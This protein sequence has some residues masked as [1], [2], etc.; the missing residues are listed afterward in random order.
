MVQYNGNNIFETFEKT[1]TYALAR[2]EKK[3]KIQLYLHYPKLYTRL[4]TDQL[5]NIETISSDVE[6]ELSEIVALSPSLPGGQVS[7]ENNTLSKI[8]TT[9]FYIYI[10]KCLICE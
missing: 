10:N 8:C 5:K 1:E 4:T 6:I 3:M 7:I 2:K 9:C